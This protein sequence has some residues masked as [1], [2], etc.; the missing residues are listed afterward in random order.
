MKL[1][2]YLVDQQDYYAVLK[3]GGELHR[4]KGDPFG[5]IEPEGT[6]DHISAVRVLAP[7]T[8]P[9]VF[10]AG[11]NYVSH[12]KE[13]GQ[14]TPELPML[15]MKPG[16]AV[17]GHDEEIILP[18]NSH[19]VHFEGELAV[20]IG[21]AGRRMSETE[22]F[23]AILGYTC[24][25]D[26]SYRP[27]QHAEMA[28][29]CMLVGKAYDTFCPLGPVIATD[30]DPAD[31]NLETRVNGTVRQRINTSDLL[32]SVVHLVSYLSQAITL[33]PGDVVITGTPSG[34]GPMQ[35]GDVV[36]IEID[37]I[38]VLRNRAVAETTA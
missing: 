28:M 36:E 33:L 3:D 15:F 31:A 7:V 8:A 11:L 1:V 4:I 21:Q 23:S 32:F 20:I 16:T 24:A 9:R 35:P 5:S 25:N 10:G 14:K 2:R 13:G 17:I 22:A 27:I 18:E 38:G 29:G 19:D 12:I 37:G 6:I 34:V 30:I 26:V